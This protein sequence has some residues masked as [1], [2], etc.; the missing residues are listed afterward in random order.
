[1]NTEY[2][3]NRRLFKKIEK[4]LNKK[5]I[6]IISGI[7]QSGKSTIL[8]KI[9]EK[10]DE[11][12]ENTLF[13]NFDYERDK[14]FLETQE[15]LLNK[16][17]LEFGTEKGY[18]FINEIQRKENAGLFLK[19]I[20]GRKLPYKFI[21]SGSGSIE[22]KEK[23]H[24]SLAGRKRIFE[25]NTTTFLEFVDYKTDYKYSNKLDT[26][27]SIET[28]KAEQFLKEYMNI[29]DSMDFGF[30]FQNF[31][32]NILQENVSN[33]YEIKYW[34]TT[35]KAEVDFII[36][37]ANEV[38]PIEIKYKKLKKASLSHSFRSFINKY[39][40]KKAYLVN[41]SLNEIMKID[42]TEVHCI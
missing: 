28:V 17:K 19:G 36:A 31:I 25:L 33:N 29:S 3:I 7:R 24:E 1:M 6:T 30:V 11:A 38:V 15:C 12:N 4:H 20:Y 42:E 22:L 8:Y 2:E 34:R 27:F 35:D 37:K 10:L 32:F 14:L 16:I 9:K 18:V 41:L 5:E 26:F 39:K 40:P 23:I 21:V 13:F